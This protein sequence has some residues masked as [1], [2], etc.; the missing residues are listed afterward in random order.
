MGKVR[1]THGIKQ[2]LADDPCSVIVYAIEQVQGQAHHRRLRRVLKRLQ[3]RKHE[4]GWVHASDAGNK[5]SRVIGARLLGFKLPEE[6]I[7]PRLSRIFENGHHMHL[8]YQNYF[9]SLPNPY[10]VTISPILRR[11]PVIGEADIILYHPHMGWIIIE[12]KSIN[13]NGFQRLTEPQLN[14]AGQVN[15]Y[16]GLFEHASAGQ[17]WYEDKND[18]NIKTYPMDFDSERFNNTFERVEQIADQ[19]IAG[20]LPDGCGECDYDDYIGSIKTKNLEERMQ[21]LRGMRE[22]NVGNH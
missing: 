11:W 3:R 12:L 9:L 8:R 5:C 7:D 20:G 13:T 15:M 1:L 21:M 17:V 18:Q 19:V 16:M 14:H 2:L 10:E 6:K 22:E 4:L